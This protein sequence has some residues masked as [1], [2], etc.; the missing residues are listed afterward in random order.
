MAR[1]SKEEI[2]FDLHKMT[3]LECLNSNTDSHRFYEED[4]IFVTL[5]LSGFSAAMA[6]RLSYKTSA[7][8]QSSAVLASRRIREPQIQILLDRVINCADN[9]LLYISKKGFKGKRRWAKWKGKQVKN[10]NTSP[11]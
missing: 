11:I 4:K 10:I 5:I 3:I 8:M 6:Y 9:G 2:Y 1:K 7:T